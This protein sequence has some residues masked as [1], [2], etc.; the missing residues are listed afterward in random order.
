MRDLSGSNDN[1]KASFWISLGGHCV[2]VFFILA[3]ALFSSFFEDEKTEPTP[4]NLM[5]PPSAMPNTQ[6]SL[7]ALPT[8][9]P[10]EIKVKDFKDLKE[11]ELPP[12]PEV[13]EIPEPPKPEPKPVKPKPKPSA[14]DSNKARQIKQRVSADDFFKNRKPQTK[15]KQR[16][17]SRNSDVKISQVK[18]DLSSKI[19]AVGSSNFYSE[20]STSEMSSYQSEVYALLRQNWILPEECTGMDLAVGV[21]FTINANGRVSSI[22]ILNSSGKIIFDK[23]VERVLKTLI[24]RSPPRGKP[25]TLAINFRA[26]D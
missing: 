24:F 19:K 17:R 13:V 10:Q 8:P 7:Q 6:E 2:C 5:P 16:S 25:L 14:K 12:E 22:K 15:P 18:T 1:F 23:S 20:V 9:T 4:F 21:R 11:I 26:Q 3:S